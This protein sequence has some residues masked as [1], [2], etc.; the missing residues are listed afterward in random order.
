MGFIPISSYR[1]QGYT[2]ITLA[3]IIVNVG[4]YLLSSYSSYFL[5]TSSDF[6]DRYGLIPLS[7]TDPTQWYRFFT[8]MFVHADILH[9][10]FN[11]YFLYV[12]GAGVEEAMGS[13]KYLL[14]YILSGLIASL[15]HISSTVIAG[16]DT[17]V[18]PAIGASGAISGVLG[19][20]LI[21]YPRR[22]LAIC[23]FLWIIPVCFQSTASNF[24]L[25]WFTLQ[26]FYSYI[27]L[28]SIAFYAHIGGFIA[29]LVLAKTLGYKRPHI[30]YYTL[31]YTPPPLREQIMES[32]IGQ[33]LSRNTR[34]VLI[35]LFTVILA[36][37]LY[38]LNYTIVN[39]HDV[40]VYSIRVEHVEE[41]IEEATSICSSDF[42]VIVYPVETMPRI[43]FNRLLWSKLITGEPG[44]RELFYEDYIETP[45]NGVKVYLLVKDTVVYDDNGVLIYSDGV[46]ATNVIHVR[47]SEVKVSDIRVFHYRVETMYRIDDIEKTI[48]FIPTIVSIIVVAVALYMTVSY[49]GERVY[50]YYQWTYYYY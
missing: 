20:Y 23:W 42:N 26:V 27:R 41:G 16:Y 24:L 5:V 10:F 17:L 9:I 1:V 50:E 36:T 46:M 40:Y 11:M 47:D 7:I 25:L 12:F 48:L 13:R 8:S 43:V 34:L 28:G 31:L 14:L 33:K 49:S 21:L 30:D 45:F 37:L 32:I 2:K 4:I 38:C 44:S 29:G 15:F 19:A 6:I 3:L 39:S 18:V 35:V 22:R